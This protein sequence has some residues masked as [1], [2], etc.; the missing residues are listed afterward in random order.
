[1]LFRPNSRTKGFTLIELLVVIAIIGLLASMAV[2]ALNVTRV[3]ARDARRKADIVQLHKSLDIAANNNGGHYP[4]TTGGVFVYAA[5]YLKCLGKNTS[6]TCFGGRFRGLD[7]LEAVLSPIIKAPADPVRVNTIFDG[8]L[9]SRSCHVTHAPGWENKPCILWLPEEP[10]TANNCHP[11]VVGS[12]GGDVCGYS[13]SF[14]A[15]K[16]GN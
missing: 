1:M 3:K 12:S 10:V 16:L 11:G 9:Y 15:L 8:Y 6:Q 2:Y 13:C 4:D 14:C 7:S 5:S